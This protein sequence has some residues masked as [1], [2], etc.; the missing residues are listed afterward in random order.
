[1]PICGRERDMLFYG[2]IF[3]TIFFPWLYATYLALNGRIAARKWTLFIA[4]AVFYAWGEPLFVPIL[5]VSTLVDYH[6]TCLL[7]TREF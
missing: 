7:P 6:L 4:S 3:S 5:L 1:M 2:P